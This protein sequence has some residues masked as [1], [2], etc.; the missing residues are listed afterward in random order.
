VEQ[1]GLVWGDNAIVS[2]AR[3]VSPAGEIHLRV[4]N[5]PGSYYLSLEATDFTL[6]VER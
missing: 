4:V 2:P 5:P 1:T 6:V 3:F